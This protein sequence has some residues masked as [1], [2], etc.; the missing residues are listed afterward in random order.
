MSIGLAVKRRAFTNGVKLLMVLSICTMV[1]GAITG[2]WFGSEKIAQM[3][4][5]SFLILK[6]IAS[7]NPKSG[8][9]VK[10][11]CFII[12]TTQLS[13]AH[14]QNFI[15]QMPSLKA[16]SQLGWLS[17]VLGLYYLVLN[18]VIDP[19]K[20][21]MPDY[22]LYMVAAGFLFVILFAQQEKGISFIKGLVRGIGGLLTTFLDGI[23]AF[24]D[25]ISYIRLFA[26]GLAT[27]AIAQS[28]NSMAAGMMEGSMG[29]VG[30][31]FILLFGHVLNLVMAM[32]SAVS[33]THLTL[34][35]N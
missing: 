17:M 30:A 35:T 24:S 27:V 13:I 19:Q 10:W 33:Y 26:V 11:L 12:G 20:Y 21:P 3:R 28:F 34:P 16:L 9:I 15:K 32:L 31:V 5:F 18:L 22:A 14:L 29:I 2:T 4:P 8:E 7:G 1:W 6:P 23:G 25:I